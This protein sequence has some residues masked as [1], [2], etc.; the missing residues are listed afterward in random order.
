MNSDS[1]FMSDVLQD[2]IDIDHAGDWTRV[3]EDLA[4][5]LLR[6]DSRVNVMVTF[7]K[8]IGTSK[9]KIE[10]SGDLLLLRIGRWWHISIG[11]DSSAALNVIKILD[12]DVT[13]I[14]IT[15]ED[16]EIFF[17]DVVASTLLEIKLSNDPSN[18]WIFTACLNEKLLLSQEK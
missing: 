15:L 8:V 7:H 11:M 4:D 10:V 18:R 16:K 9:S 12:D 17:A 14:T 5:M 13:R 3:P 2:S 6:D 1:V